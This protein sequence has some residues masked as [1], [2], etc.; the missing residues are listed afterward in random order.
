MA[1]VLVTNQNNVTLPMIVW[2]LWLG[3]SLNQAAAANVVILACMLPLL[4]LYL[5]FGRKSRF[6]EA[7]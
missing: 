3:G 6:E 1:S 7:L 2:G 5:T 4:L